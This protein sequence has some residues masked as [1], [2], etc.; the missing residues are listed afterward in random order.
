MQP[1]PKIVRQRLRGPT[2]VS[3][4]HPDADLLTAFAEKSL[5]DPERAR[6]T[7]HLARCGDCR[8]IVA[9]ALPVI[10]DTTT[11]GVRPANVSRTG[12]FLRWGVVAAGITLA[13]SVGVVQ[14]RQRHSTRALQRQEVAASTPAPAHLESDRVENGR[15]K[16]D[17]PS[18]NAE[19]ERRPASKSEID[20]A[21]F[22]PNVTS[23]VPPQPNRGDNANLRRLYPGTAGGVLGGSTGQ[24]RKFATATAPRDLDSAQSLK[25][26]A[27]APEAPEKQ[28]SARS[29]L[30]AATSETVQVTAAAPAIQAAPATVNGRAQSELSLDKAQVAKAKPP[31][32]NG[33]LSLAPVAVVPTEG[34]APVPPLSEVVEVYSVPASR[35]TI[36]A[37]G[38]LQRSLDGGKTWTDVNLSAQSS[39]G[40]NYV[41]TRNAPP[42]TDSAS[43]RK[44]GGNHPEGKFTGRI[45]FRAVSA[46]G[47]EVWAGGV[48]GVLYHS[49]DGGESWTRV[50]PAAAG[51][52]LTGDII[53]IEFTDQRNGK[54]TTSHPET[55]TTA[56]AGQSW[57]KQ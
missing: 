1:L 53:T 37:S 2:S 6:V 42:Q 5:Q 8:E 44:A 4:L 20:Q 35:W 23:R 52:T 15:R 30:P 10:E 49:S 45:V 31:V 25:N 27:A 26:S 51:V 13:V 50:V 24:R 39:P 33:D 29:S 3:D 21:R 18:P 17:L 19:K 32:S 56:D 7:G 57:Q 54:L 40:T 41:L 55:W 22:A 12:W 14:L 16:K 34:S 36:T 46:A 11:V 28:L 43:T 48:S 9:L 47:A 38:A